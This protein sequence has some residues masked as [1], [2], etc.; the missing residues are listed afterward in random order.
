MMPE[1]MTPELRD[2][3]MQ[4][5]LRR[6]EEFVRKALQHVAE[7]ADLRTHAQMAM[8]VFLRRELGNDIDLDAYEVVLGPDA[9]ELVTWVH[10]KPIGAIERLGRLVEHE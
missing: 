3:L 7:R 2:R 4:R 6:C 9:P 1:G 8:R 10:V 5:V